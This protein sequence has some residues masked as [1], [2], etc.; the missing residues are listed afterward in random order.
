MGTGVP[1]SL[2]DVVKATIVVVATTILLFFAAT[3]FT[4]GT[5]ILGQA[6]GFVYVAVME[7]ML[8][9]A[10]WWFGLRRYGISLQA[11]GLK[12]SLNNGATL[13]LAVF[14]ASVGFALFYAMAVNLLGIEEMSPQPLPSE[15]LDT[16]PERIVAFVMIVAVAPVAE[17]VFFR[18][19][20]LPVLAGRWGFWKGA[21][22][23]SL[24]F[25]AGHLALGS[26]IPAFASGILLAWLYKRT[27][28]LWNS[29]MAHA[30]QNALAFAVA[31]SV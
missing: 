18:G 11:L 27:G 20:M 26:I 21:C 2:R 30:A 1:W 3:Q 14:L 15:M 17:E 29:C 24:L 6:S 4:R 12:S 22:L 7:G 9:A 8:M 28:S 13:A 23:V 31:V 5:G 19:F 10:A 25:A 16:F